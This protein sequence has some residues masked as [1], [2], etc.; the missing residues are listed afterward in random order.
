M[1]RNQ[2]CQYKPYCFLFKNGVE[3]FGVVDPTLNVMQF[4]IH[5]SLW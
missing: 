3:F 4:V 5:G 1:N 2:F